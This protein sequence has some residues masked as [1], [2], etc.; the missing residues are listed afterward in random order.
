LHRVA[1]VH[2]LGLPEYGAAGFLRGPAEPDERCL[3]NRGKDGV[4]YVHWLMLG[5]AAASAKSPVPEL[6]GDSSLA[7]GL[8]RIARFRPSRGIGQPFARLLDQPFELV[9]VSLHD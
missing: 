6:V 4:S 2:E 1:G 5:A 3:A 9:G 8:G 7:P